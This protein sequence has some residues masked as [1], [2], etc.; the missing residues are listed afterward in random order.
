MK[1]KWKRLKNIVCIFI[2]SLLLFCIF[3]LMEHQFLPKLKEISH[4]QCKITANEMINK[5][6]LH[7][8]NIIDSSSLLTE[9][10]NTYTANTV[11][12][13]QFCTNLSMDITDEL[14]RI[15]PE[16]I[17]IPIG[18]VTNLSFLADKGPEIPFR[19]IPMGAVDVGYETAFSS[20]GINQVNYKIWINISIE[21]K[22]VTPLYQ[23]PIQMQR[24]IMLADLIF[25]GKVPEHYFQLTPK[26]EY[27]LT[28]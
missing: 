14:K 13:N 17:S 7:N 11:V 18:A 24:K 15:D 26:S 6:V 16:S 8:M 1:R 4:M 3:I 10:D 12:A 28:E 21:L 9:T 22:I 5:A 25:K 23:E 27:L 2:G 19:L 20:A